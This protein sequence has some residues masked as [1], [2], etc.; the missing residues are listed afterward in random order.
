MGKSQ[1]R[2]GLIL[3]FLAVRSNLEVGS[4]FLFFSTKGENFIFCYTVKV[5]LFDLQVSQV[6]VKVEMWQNVLVKI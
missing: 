5:K 4:Q 2:Y 3:Y 6:S 1:E